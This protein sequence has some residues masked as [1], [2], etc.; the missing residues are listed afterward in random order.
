MTFRAV[1]YKWDLTVR[2]PGTIHFLHSFGRKVLSEHRILA[3][4]QE[5]IWLRGCMKY[6]KRCKNARNVYLWSMQGHK[7]GLQ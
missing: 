5:A 7:S 3:T 6:F 1:W 2:T 4:E